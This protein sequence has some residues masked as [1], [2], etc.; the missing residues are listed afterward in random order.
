MIALKIN[1]IKIFMEK[2]LT[3]EVFD[4]FQVEEVTIATAIS[5]ENFL[6]AKATKPQ[7]ITTVL[8]HYG[9]NFVP[10]ALI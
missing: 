3:T 2:L 5:T 9:R 7:T 10:S 4:N 1:N 6:P 8:F